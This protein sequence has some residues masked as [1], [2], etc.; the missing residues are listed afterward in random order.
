MP[1]TSTYLALAPPCI[2]RPTFD[3]ATNSPRFGYATFAHINSK[4]L[5][6]TDVLAGAETETNNETTA[7]PHNHRADH[8]SS[9]WG[10]FDREPINLLVIRSLAKGDGPF[11]NMFASLVSSA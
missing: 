10:R 11:Y 6:E 5:T 3:I 8:S 9:S 1:R 2:P 4:T 7:W